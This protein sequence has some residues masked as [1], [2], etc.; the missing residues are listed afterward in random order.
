MQVEQFI[1]QV[2][3]FFDGLVQRATDDEL[4]ASGYLR[5]HVDLA[6]GLREVT[7]EEFSL[8]ELTADVEQS[9]HKAIEQGELNEHDQALVLNLWAQVQQFS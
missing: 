3:D 5:G 8:S 1:T 2:A 4:F 6:I 7:E 9:L